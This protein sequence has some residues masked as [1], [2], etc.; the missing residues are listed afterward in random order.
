MDTVKSLV[1]VTGDKG[2]IYDDDRDT[3]DIVP[4]LRPFN[5]YPSIEDDDEY[6]ASYRSSLLEP[7]PAYRLPP[8]E[9]RSLDYAS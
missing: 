3:Y 7:P 8:Y 1:D 9:E 6:I 2:Q 4:P 5:E